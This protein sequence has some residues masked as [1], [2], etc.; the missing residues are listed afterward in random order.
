MCYISK[1]FFVSLKN[2]P[3][4]SPDHR[5]LSL[6]SHTC[7]IVLPIFHLECS[8]WT[9]F[10]KYRSFLIWVCSMWTGWITW[11]HD[12]DKTFFKRTVIQSNLALTIWRDWI[13]FLLNC[14]F[15]YPRIVSIKKLLWRDFQ[16]IL[17]HRGWLIDIRYTVRINWM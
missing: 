8:W 4:Q 10:A 2:E 1:T 13:F 5:N 16:I 14:S 7:T 17:S 6:P 15:C 12:M 3:F 11:K 9:F